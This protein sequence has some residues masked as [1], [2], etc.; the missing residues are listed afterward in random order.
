MEG[1]GRKLIEFEFKGIEVEVTV[2]MERYE[3]RDSG[4]H[5]KNHF[6]RN[7]HVMV[8]F[9]DFVIHNDLYELALVKSTLSYFMQAYWKRNSKTGS[10][11]ELAT[12]LEHFH[13]RYPQSL[14]LIARQKNGMHSLEVSLT[15]N[16]K[17]AGEI[18]LSGQVVIMLDITI[19][20]AINLLTQK[21]RTTK[22][23][24][25]TINGGTI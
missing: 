3:F 12:A 15:E 22:Q 19:G 14:N 18:Y 7:A 17:P 4:G 16:G 5:H 1:G 6:N 25:F 2:E 10:K 21:Q 13:G 23:T 20:K 9:W 11:I 24:H 8:R